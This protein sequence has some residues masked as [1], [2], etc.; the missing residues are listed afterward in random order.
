MRLLRS[1]QEFRGAGRY[2]PRPGDRAARRRSHATGWLMRISRADRSVFGQWWLSF[3]RILV[4][5]LLMLAAAGVILS[6]AASPSIALR[7][8]LPALYFAERQM[9]FAALGVGVMLAISMLSPRS[10]RR[11]ALVVFVAA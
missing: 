3:D 4:G 5:A 11:L 9:I 1:V 8:G 10:I 2:L 7:K 6:L